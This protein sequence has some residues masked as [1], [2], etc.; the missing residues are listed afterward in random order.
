MK[1][2]FIYSTQF[3][4]PDSLHF[5]WILKEYGVVQLLDI[6]KPTGISLRFALMRDLHFDQI[7]GNIT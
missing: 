3:Y 7:V 1:I 5:I 6:R 2:Y 4:V